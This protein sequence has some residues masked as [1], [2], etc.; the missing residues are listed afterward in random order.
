MNITSPNE[1]MEALRE[2]NTIELELVSGGIPTPDPMVH[3]QQENLPEVGKRLA[4]RP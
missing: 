3:R 1:S 2:L 4:E